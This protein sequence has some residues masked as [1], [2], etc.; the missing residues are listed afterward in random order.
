MTDRRPASLILAGDDPEN[1]MN[2]GMA[3]A[4][5][6]LCLE[7]PSPC[8][9]CPNCRK[10]LAGQHVDV[11]VI[12]EGEGAAIKV[13][14]VRRLRADAFVRPFDSEGKVYIIR[15]ADSLNTAAQNALLILLEE[16]PKYARFILLCQN[17]GT[18]LPT[19]RSRCVIRRLPPRSQQVVASPESSERAERYVNTIFSDWGRA[20]AA[21]SWEKL[22]REE[23]HQVLV[24][25]LNELR[26]RLD[27][28]DADT[29]FFLLDRMDLVSECIS[30]LG[31]NASVGSL[32]G[33]LAL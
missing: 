10:V 30:A 6:W 21:F 13:D 22:N 1:L 28:A 8:R 17:T 12:D 20:E 2:A 3:L 7:N 32:C 27:N 15:Y 19:V 31:Q 33:I 29:R 16:P 23:L 14:V 26:A 4:A 5:E 18:L 25:L 24:C 9:A 11:A